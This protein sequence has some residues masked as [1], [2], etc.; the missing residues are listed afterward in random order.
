MMSRRALLDWSVL[1]ALVI[2]WGS[3][4]AGLKIAVEG[5]HPAWVASMRLS[6]AAL[7]L[8]VVMRGRGEP[9]P[10]LRPTPDPVWWT[11]AGLG[12]FGM[13]APFLLFAWAATELPSAVLAIC[14]GVSPVFTALFAHAFLAGERLNKRKSVGVSLGLVGFLV[15]VAPDVRATGM[16]TA[17]LAELAALAGAVFYAVSNVVTKKA[18]PVPTVTS[19]FIMCLAGA[20]ATAVAALLWAGPPPLPGARV[21]MM[22]VALG[23]LP[24]ALGTI[25]YVW[26]IRRRG[27]LSTSFTP[28]PP[29]VW[30]I[31]FAVALLSERPERAE[32]LAL[33]LILLGVGVANLRDKTVE[34]PPSPAGQ[35]A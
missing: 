14:N 30:A 26:L 22:V 10:R 27:A 6:V 1:A 11:Y 29:P 13:G 21:G 18:P 35:P 25:G 17:V 31:L 15:L 9:A 33:A 16:G 4:F 12:V 23:L 5:L 20:L 2:I 24:T 8:F 28:S 19:A 34:R 3:A 32:Y 7:A